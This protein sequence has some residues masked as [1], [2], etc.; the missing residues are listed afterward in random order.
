M[1]NRVFLVGHKAS[2]VQMLKNKFQEFSDL[3]YEKLDKIVDILYDN[4]ALFNGDVDDLEEE[5]SEL[6]DELESLETQLELV[7]DTNEE[8]VI[9]SKELVH[10]HNTIVSELNSRH[11]DTKKV[12][13][14]EEKFD[15]ITRKIY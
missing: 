12:E 6:H 11:P 15:A 4:Y 13:E 14:L 2:D 1:D 7:G 9:N 5:V 8:L 3:P 10:L